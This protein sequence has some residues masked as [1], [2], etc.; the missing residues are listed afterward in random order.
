MRKLVI[1]LP[2]L[3]VSVWMGWSPSVRAL[4][5]GYGETA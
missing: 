2:L 1:R 3:A 4:D 5:L